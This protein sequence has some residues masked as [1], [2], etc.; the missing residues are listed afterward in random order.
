[1]LRSDLFEVG[2][3]ASDKGFRVVIGTNGT[4]VTEEMT[5]KM[6]SVPVSRISVSI[7]FPTP[8]LQDEFRGQAGAFDTAIEGVKNAR[9]AGIEVQIN[10]TVTRKNVSFLP[11]LVELAL[12]LDA[13][14]F[15]P[16]MLVPTG[17]GKGWQRKSFP[18]G[19]QKTL[20]WICRKQK[21]LEGRLMFK[22]PM[23]L[24]TTAS[25]ASAA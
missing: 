3:Y 2:R 12:S 21:E 15:H 14:A 10:S 13:A 1:L 16:F 6:Q 5:Q 19:L 9:K 22:P 17:R 4:L 23:P 25:P 7:D 11:E 20:E 24:I 8:A 18:S